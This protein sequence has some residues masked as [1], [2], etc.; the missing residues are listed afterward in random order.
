M[1][2]NRA[3]GL[4]GRRDR[5]R[6]GESRG[7]P[8]PRGSQLHRGGIVGRW[9][10]MHREACPSGTGVTPPCEC[11]RPSL[12]PTSKGTRARM[13]SIARTLFGC[14]CSH[15]DAWSRPDGVSAGSSPA[16]TLPTQASPRSFRA[17][18]AVPTEEGQAIGRARRERWDLFRAW[19][20]RL[21]TPSLWS[22]CTDTAGG[23]SSRASPD[24]AL[25]Y[26]A[27]TCADRR[28]TGVKGPFIPLGCSISHSSIFATTRS[29]IPRLNP[30]TS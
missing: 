25:V 17:V 28:V 12:P 8:G 15:G 19:P 26:C 21:P 5:R 29:S 14:Q 11:S 2:R 3:S 30:G 20:S 10:V 27:R 22:D 4:I 16:N 13:T 6:I 7:A 24:S 18:P 9:V 23:G 1:H